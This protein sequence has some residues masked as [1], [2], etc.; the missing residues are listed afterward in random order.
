MQ[1]EGKLKWQDTTGMN[2]SVTFPDGNKPDDEGYRDGK[3][4]GTYIEVEGYYISNTVANPGKGRIVYR[5]MLGKDTERD[6]N[7]ERNFHYKFTLRF[8]GYANDVDW[9]IEY[10]EDKG[11]YAPNPYFISYL[12]DHEMMLPLKIKGKPV[13]KLK[14]EIV[15]NNWGPHEAAASSNI[16]GAR[17]TP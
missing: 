11:I 16:T 17:C 14:A 6:Y 8:R 7:A 9:H 1:G 15:E 12:Y 3:P 2:S 5:F 10:D 4:C 13:G